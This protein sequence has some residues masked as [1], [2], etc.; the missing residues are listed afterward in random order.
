MVSKKL[1]T[2]YEFSDIYEYFDYIVTSRINGQIKQAKDLYKK[3]SKAQKTEF[4][5]WFDTSTSFVAQSE[6]ETN[7]VNDLKTILLG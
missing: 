1:I 7:Y 2:G 4:W 6:E 5:E 3:L